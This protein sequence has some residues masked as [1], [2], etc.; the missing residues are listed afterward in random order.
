MSRFI[1]IFLAVALIAPIAAPAYAQERVRPKLEK[2]TLDAVAL[3]TRII[4]R[5]RAR[6]LMPKFQ[7]R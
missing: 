6:I 3:T 7:K 5:E 4:V 1:T 2:A